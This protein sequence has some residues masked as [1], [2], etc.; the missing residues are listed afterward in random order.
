MPLEILVVLFTVVAAGLALIATIFTLEQRSFGERLKGAF[1]LLW[2][3]RFPGA[4]Q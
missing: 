3:A 2:E 1:A 4:N